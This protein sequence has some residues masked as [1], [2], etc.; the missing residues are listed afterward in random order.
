MCSFESSKIQSKDVVTN[1]FV[2]L[3]E[4]MQQ[5]HKKEE[6]CLKPLLRDGC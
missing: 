5:G 1:F 6:N 4:S 3:S 2:A